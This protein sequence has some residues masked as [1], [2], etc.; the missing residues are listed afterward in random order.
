M[1][2]A[3]WHRKQRERDV[4]LAGGNGAR[5]AAL[6]TGKN[7]RLNRGARAPRP[8]RDRCAHSRRIHSH[9]LCKL[10]SSRSSVFSLM[11][12]KGKGRIE[13]RTSSCTPRRRATTRRRRRRRRA[14]RRSTPTPTKRDRSWTGSPARCSK[15]I[16]AARTTRRRGDD[17]HAG[18]RAEARA[19]ARARE[20]APSRTT[21]AFAAGEPQR[22]EARFGKDTSALAR[23]C[24]LMRSEAEHT[25]NPL[26]EGDGE[27]QTD[28]VTRREALGS[29]SHSVPRCPHPKRPRRG[30]R[31]RCCFSG[32]K[33][34]RDR[35]SSRRASS[36]VGRYRSASRRWRPAS[37]QARATGVPRRRSARPSP[38]QPRPCI[39]RAKS[40]LGLA[41][42]AAG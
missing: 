7:R 19:Q 6:A 20:S 4:H 24:W 29:N 27:G 23:S 30:R 15:S 8:A 22:P 18:R 35:L 26:H 14:W 41:S 16:A 34:R 39:R 37:R 33:P 11:D 12:V 40:L 2:G 21:H 17:P 10:R 36:I 13:P 42:R 32:R 5:K 28:P 9:A 3:L 1:V 25:M 31:A 38:W